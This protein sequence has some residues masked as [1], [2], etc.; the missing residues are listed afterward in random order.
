MGVS[1]PGP[2]D[3]VVSVDTALI[4]EDAV[5][6]W[7]SANDLSEPDDEVV[8]ETTGHIE[9][10]D[11][12]VS[13]ADEHDLQQA[14]E[15]ALT[16]DDRPSDDIVSAPNTAAD[17]E[18][19]ETVE[20]DASDED[21]GALNREKTPLT[22]PDADT[23]DDKAGSSPQSAPAF[24]D[25]VVT[26]ESE[27][28]TADDTAMGWRGV[29]GRLLGRARRAFGRADAT[30]VKPK[31]RRA[32]RQSE[33]DSTATPRR[34]RSASAKPRAKRA[35]AA[36][37]KTGLWGRLLAGVGL[38]TPAKAKAKR[39]RKPTTA[40]SAPRKPRTRRAAQKPVQKGLFARTL[41]RFGFGGKADIEA[42][43]TVSAPEGAAST[44]AA[45]A[46]KKRATAK[47][48]STPRKP[49]SPRA[50]RAKANAKHES[51]WRRA[52]R[53]VLGRS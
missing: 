30:E 3:D 44:D 41:A 36:A 1:A 20:R 24:S 17:V 16:S 10:P 9:K 28:L 15:A 53:R 29:A 49:A 2:A 7:E 18:Q 23:A 6:E 42:E 12:V 27:P 48:A 51:A 26:D 21:L 5:A 37:K 25:D 14:L 8:R 45:P 43:P 47:R 22:Q 38:A 19:V 31:K 35:P 46:R 33:G 11:A 40:R 50:P 39:P 32:R 4:A 34:K 13:T 52:L